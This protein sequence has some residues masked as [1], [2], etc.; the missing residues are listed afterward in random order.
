MP[1]NQKVKLRHQEL[2]AARK[3]DVE[4]EVLPRQVPVHKKSGWREVAAP[5]VTPNKKE[6]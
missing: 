5:G 4:I 3:T 2:S 6:S 1:K